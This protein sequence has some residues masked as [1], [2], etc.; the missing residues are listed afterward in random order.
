MVARATICGIVVDVEESRGGREAT[1]RSQ[2]CLQGACMLAVSSPPT[3][4]PGGRAGACVLAVS[5]PPTAEPRRSSSPPPPPEEEFRAVVA[6][7][8]ALPTTR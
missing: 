5:S 4:V 8:E 3:A 7:V 6:Y 1:A 2:M